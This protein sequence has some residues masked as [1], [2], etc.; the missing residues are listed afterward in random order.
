MI[1]LFTR[2]M[3]TLILPESAAL[4]PFPIDDDTS[5]LSAILLNNEYYEF[6]LDGRIQINGITILDAGY[7][8]PFKAKAWLDL[9]DRKSVG[10]TI[11]SKNIRKH[12]NDIFRL[13]VL[14]GQNARI[15]VT[16]GIYKDIQMFLHAMRQED[17]NTKQ[18]G[19]SR[20]KDAIL[21]ILSNTYLK[22]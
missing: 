20:T 5:S 15:N 10:E 8:I 18:L 4:T 1:E 13:S 17:I 22:S 11:D 19:L 6:L 9:T 14:L 16:S 12:K 2:R 3:D 21:E 7:L